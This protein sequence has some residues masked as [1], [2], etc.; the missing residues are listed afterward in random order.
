MA[1][2]IYQAYLQ[3]QMDP[4]YEYI[5]KAITSILFM[6]TPHRGSNLAE[7]LNRILQVSLISSSKNYVSDLIKNSL[8]L[9]KI[10]DQFRHIAPKLD[11]VSFY[12]TQPT[13]IGFSMNRIVSLLC[14]YCFKLPEANIVG[15]WWWRKTHPF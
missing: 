4:E 9:Q 7:T 14:T 12:E 5:I 15:R 10:N 8:A 2:A 11:I 1:N 6:A 13:P 3:G